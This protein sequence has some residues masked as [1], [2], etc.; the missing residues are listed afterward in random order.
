MSIKR[1]QMFGGEGS[2][3]THDTTCEKFKNRNFS[4]N[5]IYK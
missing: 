4:I 1:H 3:A 2:C 5:I